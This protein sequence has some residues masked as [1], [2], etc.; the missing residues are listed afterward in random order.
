M[1][2]LREYFK[3]IVL[4]TTTAAIESAI[5]GSPNNLDDLNVSGIATIGSS[6]GLGTMTVV[7]EPLL[8]H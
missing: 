3:V 2:S 8:V 7:L 4:T 6:T 5:T 1:L